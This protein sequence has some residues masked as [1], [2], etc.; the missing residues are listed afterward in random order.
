MQNQQGL[1]VTMQN[2]YNIASKSKEIGGAN[3]IGGNG[4]NELKVCVAIV[5]SL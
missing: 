5:M 2:N 4:Y 1:M 3:A